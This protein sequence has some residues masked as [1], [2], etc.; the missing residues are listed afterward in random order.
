MDATDFQLAFERA[1]QLFG[2]NAVVG[3][4]YAWQTE[5]VT[6]SCWVGYRVDHHSIRVL[7]TGLFWEEA[8]KNA[9]TERSM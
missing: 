6:W 4:E 8:F 3:V 1:Q 7:G 5:G 9:K 2:H